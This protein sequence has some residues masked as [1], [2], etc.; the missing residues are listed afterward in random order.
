MEWAVPLSDVDIGDEE[1]AAVG[2]VLRSKWLS[3]GEVTSRFETEF[4]RAVGTKHAIAVT[5]AT[6]A[7][8]LACSVVG[9]GPGTDV[10]VPSL[11]F[12]ATANAVM[13]AGGRPVFAEI[14]GGGDLNICPESVAR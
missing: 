7:L 5:N 6:A 12:V 2:A 13:H 8:H 10:I 1:V 11:T 9:V 3:M 14:N 4:A